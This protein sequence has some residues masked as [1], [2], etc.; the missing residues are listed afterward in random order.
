MGRFL[1]SLSALI[2]AVGAAESQTMGAGAFNNLSPDLDRQ[3]VQIYVE[4]IRAIQDSGATPEQIQQQIQGNLYF[5]GMCAIEREILFGITGENALAG[6]A[7]TIR[8]HFSLLTQAMERLSLANAAQSEA[9]YQ[10]LKPQNTAYVKNLYA[11]GSKG[12]DAQAREAMLN[13][14]NTCRQVTLAARNV[15]AMAI[16]R[17]QQG[18]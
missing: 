18:R 4:Q 6:D 11:A 15:D 5:T 10:A 14:S 1:I 13:F 12:D 7:S 16:S 9:E 8:T 17:Q 2:M 3:K